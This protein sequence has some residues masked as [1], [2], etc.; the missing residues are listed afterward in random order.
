[1]DL[2]T[3]YM[4]VSDL[5]SLNINVEVGVDFMLAMCMCVGCGIFLDLTTTLQSPYRTNKH[6]K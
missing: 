1:M 6:H 5:M 4:I 3:M 2:V